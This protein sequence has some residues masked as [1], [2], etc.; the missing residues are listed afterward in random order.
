MVE[1]LNVNSVKGAQENIKA[2]ILGILAKV[3]RPGIEKAV[4]FFKE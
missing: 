1:Q 2:E 4:E 3:E